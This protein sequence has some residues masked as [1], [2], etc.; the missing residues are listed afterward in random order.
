MPRGDG[1]GP[2]GHG[3]KTGLGAGSCSANPGPDKVPEVQG[4]GFGAGCGCGHGFGG[5]RG[6]GRRRR[7]WS[8]LAQPSPEE[9]QRFLEDH[10][11]TLQSRLNDI[12]RRLG[13]LATKE[14]K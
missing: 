5:G 3:P 9:E 14:P 12:N 6:L 7:G 13:E 8:S 1:T 11:N 10:R 2:M 4:R